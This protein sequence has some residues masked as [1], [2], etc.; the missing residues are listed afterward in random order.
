VAV[1]SPDGRCRSP[2]CLP[3]SPRQELLKSVVANIQDRMPVILARAD[4]ARWLGQEP[5]SRPDAA[6]PS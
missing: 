2:R 5:A 4:Y 6:L 3:S 1:E